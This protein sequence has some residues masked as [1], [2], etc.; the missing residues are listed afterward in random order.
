MPHLRSL[1]ARHSAELLDCSTDFIDSHIRQGTINSFALRSPNPGATRKMIRIPIEEL[2]K[3][4]EERPGLNSLVDNA[5]K[6]W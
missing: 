2:L 6:D 1:S 5:I 3:I 4:I